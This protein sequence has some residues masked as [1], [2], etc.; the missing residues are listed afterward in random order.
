MAAGDGVVVRASFHDQ[1]GQVIVIDHGSI[2]D[3]GQRV[4]TL[5]AHLS[6]LS[7]QT[8]DV[9]AAGDKIG[10]SGGE[11]G[12]WYSGRSEGPHLHYEV[13]QA[14]DAAPLPW[15]EEG[16]MGVGP[17]QYRQDP[18]LWRGSEADPEIVPVAFHAEPEFVV[19]LME[20]TG[21]EDVE[22]DEGTDPGEDPPEEDVEQDESPIEVASDEFE[23]FQTS[24]PI[25]LDLDGDGVE[26]RALGSGT[27]FDHAG[28]GFRE[29]TGWVGSDDGLLVLDR[30]GNGQIDDGRELFGNL[31]P[32]AS[33]TAAGDGYEALAELDTNGDGRVDAGDP[34][35]A[36]VRVW[37]DTDG[38]GVSTAEELHT[39]SA[40][41]VAA[42]A[43]T[44]TPST[45]VDEEG[46]EHRL[47]GALTRMDGTVGATADV[48]L[49]VNRLYSFAADP[50]EVPADVAALPNA[51]GYGTVHDLRQAMAR[52]TT[53][54]LKGL[55]Q[56][57]AGEPDPARRAALLDRILFAWTGSDAVD[58]TSRGAFIDARR[59]AVLE[60]ICGEAFVGIEGTGDP[61][62][63]VAGLLDGSY[64]TV[65]ELVGAQLLAQTHVRDLWER[66]IYR[67]D[68][69][70]RELSG[71]LSA[72]AAE[73]HGRLAADPAGGMVALSEFARSVRGFGLERFFDYESFRDA[74]AAE[75][76]DIA[77]A[78]DAGGRTL[79]VATPG[80]DVVTGDSTADA[81]RGG[82]GDDTLSGE[83]GDDVLYGQGGADSLV[84]G[85]D[86]DLLD[87]GDGNDSLAGRRG[88]D[89]LFGQ[90]GADSLLGEAGA[91]RLDG[92]DG[93][94]TLDGGEGDDILQGRAGA[95]TLLGR[96]QDDVLVGGDGDDA[97]TGNRGNDVLA[98][99]I[100][101]DS[102]S[103]E[104]GEDVLDG[105][106]GD[107]I[108][109]G[110]T[111]NDT[112]RFGRGG[113]HDV[114]VDRDST[115]G[116]RDVLELDA[117]IEPADLQVRRE[118]DDLVL[119][120]IGTADQVRITAWFAETVPGQHEVEEVR[121]ASGMVWD[122]EMVRQ[123][124]IVSSDGPDS[125]VGYENADMLRG[126][127]GDDTLA[128]RGG[129][130]NLDGGEGNDVLSG[131]GG[132]DTLLGGPGMDSLRGNEGNDTLRGGTGDDALA[133]DRDDDVLSG[134][135][136]NDS[137]AGGG[138]ADIL[139]GGAGHDTLD[140][141]SEDDSLDGGEGNDALTGDNGDDV[142]RGGSG[143][144]MLSGN[145]GRDALY[146][147]GDD[148]VLLGDRDDDVLAGEAGGDR[149]DGGFGS[150]AMAGGTGDDTYVV[151]ALTDTVAE[152]AGEGTDTV[153]TAIAY[154][155]PAD[156]ERL[157]LT[158]T[159]AVGGTG[160]GLN[161]TLTGNVAANRLDGGAGA[162]AMA[163]GAGDDIYIVDDAADT[164]TEA[165]G[166]GTDTVEASETYALPSNVE[167][168]VLTGTADI[169]GRGNELNNALTGNSAANRLDGGAGDDT[170]AGGAGDDVYV[171]DS[172]ADLVMERP[173]GGMDTVESSVS[174]A[175]VEALES[176]RLTGTDA[177][178]GTGNV[179]NN[180][181]TGN[182]AANALDGG[183]GDDVLDGGGGP[184]LLIGGTG[185]DRY[186]VSD[187]GDRVSERAG[188]GIDTVETAVAFTLPTDVEDLVVT[189][190]SAI[191]GTGNAQ[192]NHLT[193]N[194]GANTLSGGAGDDALDGGTGNDTLIGGT[195]ND[196]YFVGETGDV[197]MELANEGIDTVV[198]AVAYALPA[199]VEN[200]TLIG[201]GAAGATGN[202]AGNTLTGNDAANRLNGGG[203]ADVMAGGAGDDTYV[204]D[205]AGDTVIEAEGAGVDTVESSVSHVLAAHVE[206]LTL[207]G[208]GAINGTG[209]SLGNTLTGNVAANALDGGAGADVMVGGAGDDTYT[210]DDPADTIIESPY[211]GTDTI[212]SWISYALPAHVE[213]LILMGAAAIDATG[214]G[215]GN[216]LT[217]NSGANV[218][219]GG[220]G[221]DTMAGGAGDD[222][223]VVDSLFDWVQEGAN[224]GNDTVRS[225]VTYAL[226]SNVENLTLTGSAAINGGGNSLR[227]VLQG[228]SASN[229]LD[230]RTGDDTY[231]FTRGG[232]QDTIVDFDLTLANRDVLAFG[233]DL[234]PI[235]LIIGRASYNLRIVVQ[236]SSDRV[237]VQNWYGGSVNRVEVIKAADGRQ[238]LSTQVDQL[239]QAMAIY[240][241]QTGLTWEQAVAQ[242]PEA[243]EGILAAYWQPAAS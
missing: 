38:D 209:N 70:T 79:L 208:S 98:G 23:V 11:V 210:V 102:L 225:A 116:N 126:L 42:L 12:A 88:D 146:G 65:V 188:E 217:G 148:D 242:R 138:G 176:L 179:L 8:G 84:G 142:L 82:D 175:L 69:Q 185:N 205:H 233:G 170:M 144:D 105:G 191:N 145:G 239:I 61:N 89:R 29:E 32:L 229:V 236:G 168:L 154:A 94:D 159:G 104:A 73:L 13:I 45:F 172:A 228:N 14:P 223:Y 164:V 25:I 207:T 240:S 46:N 156:V 118:G 55:V 106:A 181:L 218:L 111:E 68:P 50:V 40:V 31:T 60:R 212:Q 211:A 20:A 163:G 224:A 6:Q 3:D 63:E 165:A 214:N 235:D 149:L 203:G 28:D 90:A 41:G 243:V 44:S 121:F 133:G 151:D 100:G 198:S 71:D 66:V 166:E 49:Q 215:S 196:T 221:I 199:N 137:L 177:I 129:D 169:D 97:L 202:A 123:L 113:G 58:P 99:E 110:G 76:E 101:S 17:Y 216:T 1:Y 48:W 112:Y 7:V 107:D 160:N 197:V 74:F 51:R 135:D 220:G 143:A 206:R 10:E 226:N 24:S 54:A 21:R 72:A 114:I 204:V 78:V 125:I 173:D 150:D 201:P 16:P 139:D 53:G 86:D 241:L 153:E 180:R 52:D 238:L 231:L 155:L 64:Q 158:G 115:P 33:G 80:D 161:N 140:G 184:D 200:L 222:V 131:D 19:D 136:G 122:R 219:D 230:G 134:E 141:G 34:A 2:G 9:V 167:G 39:L 120:I 85:A 30:N 192:D 35:W 152:A 67:W 174:Y 62:E 26:T 47:V 186:V 77:W 103:G 91:D 18:Y 36:Q 57:F 5:Y 189:G 27:Y 128:G 132:N 87:G 15:R 195:G 130:D 162:D 194:G 182:S 22:S 81:A 83:A 124:V 193:G 37:R 183:A 56:Q 75:G 92:G 232:G 93:D 234:D 237:D 4:Y 171:V 119:Q 157:V 147:G 95:D 96:E 187:A 213:R 178:T 108:L 117:G 109:D 59:L 43:T 127:G 227:N 190:T